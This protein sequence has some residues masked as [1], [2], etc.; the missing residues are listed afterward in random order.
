MARLN[1]T[2]GRPVTM[3][4]LDTNI[5]LY[6]EKFK[7]DIFSQIKEQFGHVKFVVPEQVVSE[8]EGFLEKKSLKKSAEIALQLLEKN[9]VLKVKVMAENAD[10]ALISLSRQAII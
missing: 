3:I 8:L 9:S 7:A 1:E 2:K 10:K 4:A 6:A 5:L